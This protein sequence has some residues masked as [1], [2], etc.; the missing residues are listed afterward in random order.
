MLPSG[1]SL[2]NVNTGIVQ[3][4]LNDPGWADRLSS[5]DM[6]GLSALFFMYINPCGRF[7]LDLDERIDFLGRA[8]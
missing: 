5:E 2:V 7:E 6:R 1:P 3:S 4:I 8:A